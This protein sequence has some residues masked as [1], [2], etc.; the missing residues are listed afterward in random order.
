[1]RPTLALAFLIL[2]A[3]ALPAVGAEVDLGPPVLV[4]AGGTPID[5]DVGHAAPYA[6]DWDGDG[7]WDL[8]VGQMGQGRLRIYRN[9]GTAAEPRFEDFTLFQ[10]GGEDATVPSG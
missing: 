6:C 5:A 4:Q 7:V 2:L 1:M 10:A 3:A 8:L 9:H